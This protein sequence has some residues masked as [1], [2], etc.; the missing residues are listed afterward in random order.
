MGAVWGPGPPPPPPSVSKVVLIS[1]HAGGSSDFL[2]SLP[3][4]FDYVSSLIL[5]NIR[6]FLNISQ[7]FFMPCW[8]N[9]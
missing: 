1:N 3:V 6:G 8:R 4:R 7:Y 5:A 2:V 9:T